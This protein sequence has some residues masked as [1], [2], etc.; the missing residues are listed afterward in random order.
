VPERATKPCTVCA[1]EIQ[2]R[3]KWER[4]WDEVRYC[5]EACRRRKLGGH[6]AALERALLD[7]LSKR[8]RD[9]SICP[10][11][12]AKIVGGPAWETLMEP[13]RQAARRL[14][15]RGVVQITQR[16]KVVDPSRA[17]G[18]IRVRLAR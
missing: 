18:P 5:S 10:S 7:L 1:R 15:A 4:D 3:K 17:K 14:V 11:E 12:A 16:G 2:W 9:S 6:D 8:D 13:A